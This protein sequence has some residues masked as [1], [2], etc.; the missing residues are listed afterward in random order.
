M[1]YLLTVADR[2]SKLE[3]MEHSGALTYRRCVTIVMHNYS[4]NWSTG[5]PGLDCETA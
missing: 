5:D 2:T 1:V 3:F 4:C